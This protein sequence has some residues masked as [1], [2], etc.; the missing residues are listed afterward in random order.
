MHS[1]PR[2]CGIIDNQPVNPLLLSLIAAARGFFGAV[3]ILLAKPPLRKEVAVLKRKQPQP[4]LKPLDRLFWTDLPTVNEHA[5][6]R[7]RNPLQP[8][9][10][11]SG[12]RRYPALGVGGGRQQ[13]YGNETSKYV[14]WSDLRRQVE[15]LQIHQAVTSRSR[16][17]HGNG[18]PAGARNPDRAQHERSIGV[19]EIGRLHRP[20]ER[21]VADRDDEFHSRPTGRRGVPDGGLVGSNLTHQHVPR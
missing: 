17:V 12:T 7:S 21:I 2:P 9:R 18:V 19:F 4:H 8:L 15:R 6:P 16:G 5:E 1:R 20:A 13:K 11:V 10:L 3:R 14:A